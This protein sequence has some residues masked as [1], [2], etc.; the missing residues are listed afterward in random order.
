MKRNRVTTAVAVA[1]RERRAQ[2]AVDRFNE[3]LRADD[4]VIVTKDDGSEVETTVIAAAECRH[5]Q[6]IV[7]L[8][9]VRGCYALDR[10]RIKPRKAGAS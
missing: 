8:E 10:V 3:Q 4:V 5:G 6:A 7:W 1:M 9:A 2:A